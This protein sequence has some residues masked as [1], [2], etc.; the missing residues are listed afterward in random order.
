MDKILAAREQIYNEFHRS[1][2]PAY[3]FVSANADQF[4]AYYTSMY[5]IADTAVY[6]DTPE[7]RL[8]VRSIRI[9]S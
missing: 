8:F 7:I 2:G 3:F 4:A 5:L 1:A 6:L 9:L